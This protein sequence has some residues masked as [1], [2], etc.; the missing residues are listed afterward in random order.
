MR[1]VLALSAAGMVAMALL[2]PELERFPEE[3]VQ[4]VIFL[5]RGR[6]R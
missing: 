5:A 6:H 4:A 2:V 1:M 3:F